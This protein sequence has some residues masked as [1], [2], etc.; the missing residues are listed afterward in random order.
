MT[1]QSVSASFMLNT[2]EI[3][4]L[5]TT[6]TD[7]TT[8]EL[9]V[10]TDYAVS[11]VSIGTYAEGKAIAQV[12]SPITAATGY[13]LYAYVNRRGNIQSILPVGRAGV[14]WT[15]QMPMASFTFEAGDTIEVF[16]VANA[17]SGRYAAYSLI[18]AQGTHAI[19]SGQAAS[20]NVALTHILSGAGIGGALTGQS[21]RSH[22]F[23]S[24]EDQLITSGNGLYI[25][26]DRGLP[27]GACS[28]TNPKNQQPI[29]NNMGGC[30]IGL[31]F[32]ARL[33]C[34]A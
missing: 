6:C 11:A 1:T 25:L 10:S 34:S 18:T 27:V 22:F 17:N 2:G 13:A 14:L 3:V 24:D 30:Q 16:C 7:D 31:N 29:M 28:A 5:R 4:D 33:S 19:F 32:V 26:N 8:T 12:I 15:P 21:I 23:V 9:L 20:G